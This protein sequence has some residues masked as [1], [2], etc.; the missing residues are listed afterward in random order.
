[1]R[2]APSESFRCDVDMCVCVFV[3]A[4]VRMCLC[5]YIYIY[6]IMCIV[7]CMY[8]TM[9]L[10]LQDFEVHVYLYVCTLDMYVG[11]PVYHSLYMFVTNAR[12]LIPR[13]QIDVDV[14]ARV[15]IKHT[16]VYTQWS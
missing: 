4:H 1:M 5:V 10:P 14:C 16:C 6:S 8:T 11:V 7:M 2:G 12:C 13:F 15:C 9:P 3:R